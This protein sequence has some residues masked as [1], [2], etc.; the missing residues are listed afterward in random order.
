MLHIYREEL[1]YDKTLSKRWDVECPNEDCDHKEAVMFLG[2]SNK[3]KD[4][5]VDLVFMCCKCKEKWIHGTA[6]GEEMEN[7]EDNEDEEI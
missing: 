6:E 7:D 2:G 5:K 3:V 1:V 4:D